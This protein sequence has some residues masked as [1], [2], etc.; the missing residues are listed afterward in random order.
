MSP[1]A[2]LRYP[3]LHGN[4][5]TFVAEDDVWMAPV[6][7]GR[8]WRVSA[9]QLPARSPKFS[10]DGTRLAWQVVQ[11]GAPEIVTADVD[12]GDF[13]QLTFWG[14][15]STRL[16]GFNSA[17]EAIATCSVEQED[18][19]LRWAFAVPLDG[20]APVKLPYG[21]V[22]TIAE[23]P[24][25]GDERPMVIGSLLTREQAWWKRYRGGTAGKLWIDADGNGEFLRLVPELDGNLSD[26]MWIDGRVVFLSDHEGYGNLYSVTPRG[27]DLRRH[28]DFEG[29]YVRHASSDGS[30]IVF[31]SAGRIW[32]LSSLDAEAEP[33]D[34]VL[35]SAGTAR[36]PRP[37][38]VAKHLSAV[39]PDTK[40]TASVVESHGT[41]HWLTHRDGPSRVIEADSTVRARLGRPLDSS[42]A[43]YVADRNGEEAI[44]I[45]DV[46]AG[47]GTVAATPAAQAGVSEGIPAAGAG[48][49]NGLVLPSPVSASGAAV[50]AVRETG[51]R[52]SGHDGGTESAEPAPTGAPGDSAAAAATI[53][54]G[55]DRPTRVS[56]LVP[57]PDGRHVGVST[58][59]GEVFVLDVATAE[60]FPVASSDFGA[61]DQLAF[62]PDSQWLAWAEPSSGEGRSRIRLRSVRD[63][64][65]PVVDI[66]DGRFSDHDP[67]FTT[68]GLYLA[69]LSE[70]SF[71]PVYDTHRFDL[72]FP[73]S[74]KPFLVALA[75]GTP[76]PFGP[77]VSGTSAAASKTTAA[78]GTEAD[79]SQDTV[80]PVQVDAERIGD[81]LI[82]VPVP[83]GRYEKL[84]AAEGGL[85]WQSSDIYGVTGDGRASAAD[86][87]PAAR[88]ERFDLEKKDVS[89]L[90][91]ALDDFEVSGDGTKVVLKHEGSV[92]MVP[93]VSRVEEDSAENIRVDLERIRIRIDPVKVWG[94][95]FDEAW[96]LQRDFFWAPDMGGLDWEGVHAR[97]RPLVQNLGSHDDLVDLLWE[98]HGE[99]G[100]SHAYVT[101]V[102]V[103]EQ[104]SGGQ[105][106]LG[107]D[108]RPGAGG[109]EVVRILGAESSDPA[110]TSPLSAPG[111]DVHPGDVIAAVDGQPVPPNEG[112]AVL[113]AGAAGRTVELTVVSAGSDGAP[114]QRRIAVVPLRS[115]E[116]LRYQ[117]WVSANRRLVREAS[118]GEFGYL[119]IPDMMANGWSQLHRDL[120]QEASLRG[121]VVDVRR[122]RGGHTSQLVAELIGRK[123]TAWSVPRGGTPTPYPAHAP[124][125]PVVILTDE[126][127]GSDGDIVTQVSKLRGI[128]PVVGTRTWGG[129]VGI[130]GRFNLVDGTMVNQP[131]H[132][133]WFTGGVG[134]DVENRGVEPDIEVAF[135]PHAYVAGDDPQLEH[136]VGILRE[137]L[138]ELPTD[139]PPA[140]SGYR[141]LQPAPLPKRP[142]ENTEEADPSL[143]APVSAGTGADGT[144]RDNRH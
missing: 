31:E 100:T 33:L 99:L 113:L 6:S 41:L 124:R 101:P 116:R 16:K 80:P 24:A 40:G 34:I 20:S 72:S 15:Q 66:T 133:Y 18:N 19:R 130:D 119:H 13:R 63:A 86:R 57:S 81:R 107:A 70:R 58:E 53:R 78:S 114:E 44:Y 27:E 62:S 1:T 32:L 96:R 87:D 46:F 50:S 29:F 131:R 85:L 12:G 67:S 22:E 61:V 3:D 128:G 111:A 30:R 69:F 42:R 49:D 90:V 47:L 122:N 9:M 4:L 74:T 118:N 117:N 68:D 84:R 112:P 97:Y 102:P 23:G 43:V 5:V 56:Q 76:S 52:G 8:A 73:S 103:T 121:L 35:G 141:N 110:A 142:Q 26:P 38:N 2:Y 104:G 14:S 126:F 91:A 98:M 139:E 115:E 120:D 144:S 136:G 105:G 125:G 39:V 7:G 37:L 134:W 48:E 36:R 17:G 132:A 65:A 64:A 71:D 10:P 143:P 94:Q 75:A 129:V 138:S 123:V 88:L 60:L 83:Q 127:A 106:F 82:A 79:T 25:V 92:R 45:K 95:A 11:G 28:T 77:S 108:L 137:M 54:V 109:W 140:M 21:P 93:A 59:Y 51:S 55:F 89:V 135:P